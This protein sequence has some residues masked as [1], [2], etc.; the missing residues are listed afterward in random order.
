MKRLSKASM[1]RLLKSDFFRE[2]REIVK[3]WDY[4]SRTGDRKLADEMMGKWL[5][6]KFALKHITGN[7]YTFTRNGS[8]SYG[9][10]NENDSEDRLING[11]ND[12]EIIRRSER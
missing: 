2:V 8:G 5:V 7:W 1:G 10:V 4:Y 12:Y 6:A 3:A 9:V 11:R